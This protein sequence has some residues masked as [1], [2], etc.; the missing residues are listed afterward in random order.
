MMMMTRNNKMMM[1]YAQRT[2]E[3]LVYLKSSAVKRQSINSVARKILMVSVTL[4]NG[5]LFS[6][7][8]TA[9][10]SIFQY[11]RGGNRIY[12]NSSFDIKAT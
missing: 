1:S 2:I 7:F 4:E 6:F 3:S 8:V 12:R 11:G 10:Q 5:T 9:R